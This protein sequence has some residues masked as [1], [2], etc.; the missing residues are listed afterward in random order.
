MRCRPTIVGEFGGG[1]ICEWGE[2]PTM[3]QFS[4]GT[5]IVGFPA[6]ITCNTHTQNG[7]DRPVISFG[8]IALTANAPHH[9]GDC[10]CVIS[11]V[12][13]LGPHNLGDCARVISVAIAPRAMQRAWHATDDGRTIQV[14]QDR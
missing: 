11:V 2:P 6:Q 12:I 1:G 13:A 8:V 7:W 9:L 4:S 14:W 10:A 3:R 5:Y